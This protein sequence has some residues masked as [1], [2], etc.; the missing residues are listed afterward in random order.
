MKKIVLLFLLL[1]NTFAWGQTNINGEA[2]YRLEI[3]GHV[4]FSGSDCGDSFTGGLQWIAI[5]KED[6]SHVTLIQG[7]DVYPYS[8]HGIRNQ[9]FF[10]QYDFDKYNPVI[11]IKYMT[12]RR[13]TTFLGLCKE[14]DET[15]TEHDIN[16]CDEISYNFH[17]LNQPGNSTEIIK[18]IVILN[19]PLDNNVYIS[20]E[21]YLTITLPNNIGDQYYNWEYSVENSNNFVAFES[22]YNNVPILHLKGKD[23]L[24][25]GDFGKPI[26]IRVNMGC[27][28]SYKSNI[29]AFT[30]LKSSPHMSNTESTDTK[31]SDT[32]DGTATVTF[33]R[34]LEPGETLQMFLLNTT[35]GVGV[36]LPN[37]GY[38]TNADLQSDLTYTIEG[39][40]AGT[41]KLN[42]QGTYQ[43]NYTYSDG[44]AHI[45]NFTINNPAPVEFDLTSKRDVYC[46]N[47]SDGFINLEASGGQSV[48][49]NTGESIFQYQLTKDNDA[50]SDWIDF[51]SQLTTSI[52]NLSAGTYTIKVR[53]SNECVAKENGAEKVITV[54]LSEPE[55]PISLPSQ[56][57]EI[58][59]PTGFGLSNGYIS[60]KVTGGTPNMDGS[61]NYE[62]RKGSPT[63]TIITT[64][65]TTDLINDPFTI[66]LDG[67]AAG[68]YYLT[69]KDKNYAD[70]SSELENC[71]IISQ[72]IIVDQPEPLVANIEVEQQI[73]CHIANDYPNKLDFDNNGVPDEVEDGILKVNVTGGVGDY[74]YQWQKLDDGTFQNIP[75]ATISTL[76]DLTAGTY[77]ILVTDANNNQTDASFT[78]VY[79]QVLVINSLSA[80]DLA[81]SNQ[82]NGTV[83][84]DATGGT[85]VISYQWN[86]GDNTATVNNLTAG[87]YFVLVND[88]KGCKVQG[89]IEITQPD[90]IVIT[91]IDVKNPIC[92]GA[93]NGFIKT[94]ISGGTPPY[95][96]AW[97]N[98]GDTSENLNLTAGNYTLTITDD[99]GCSL[100][101]E[102]TLTDP[103]PL[104]ID[105]GEDVTLCLGRTIDYDV[106]IDDDLA[107]YEWK[108]QNGN[109]ISTEATITL[110]EEGIYSVLVTDSKGCTGMDTVQIIKSNEV[111][112]PQFMLTT[113]AYTE[114]DVILVNT[115]PVA[116]EEVEWI[117]PDNENIQ[118]IDQTDEFLQLHFSEIGSYEFGLKGIQGDC[119][120]TFYKT[121]VIEENTQ[122]VV[123][124][125][126]TSSNIK[127]FEIT[128]NPNDGIFTV[129]VDLNN[130][131]SIRLKMID[132]VSHQVLPVVN[133]PKGDHFDVP[134]NTGLI[135]GTYLIILETGGEAMVKRVLIQ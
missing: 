107:M 13:G 105:L 50:P 122:G 92:N 35:T 84:V 129:T 15:I 2:K 21:E 71:G 9:N 127:K 106:S 36:Q 32:N 46:H 74:A 99:K 51:G 58:V 133:L 118:I 44:S 53:D 42:L 94:E 10:A 68:N 18:P 56:N 102:Y 7:S 43:G 1:I 126:A 14:T 12:S 124:N 98:G 37:D 120:E 95:T 48:G 135:S 61:Y 130:L 27:S 119:V 55:E 75:N 112:N 72:K 128:P 104:I 40:S 52:Q 86:T 114:S 97:S 38:V 117:I 16:I 57:I 65:I 3:D 123:I 63:G 34:F 11:K 19:T 39:L 82:N 77:K 31:C 90:Q 113:Y 41:Y 109:V 89:N 121:V 81:C 5:M 132:M 67:L 29:I 116:P 33:D 60:V 100:S 85:G 134:F 66:K 83:S 76:S 49:A 78:L 62:W 73:S 23:F 17:D 108:D 22:Q 28:N 101:R 70:A 96:I 45:Y 111:L 69:V 8:G 64:G 91:D 24:T 20:S 125:P 6:N 87:N 25:N 80:N 110:S 103:E 59:Q 47:G 131:A 115:S 79:P 4:G 54:V 93:D 88:A 30:Y 26:Y